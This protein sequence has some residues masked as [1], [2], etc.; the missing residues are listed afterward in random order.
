[1]YIVTRM[2]NPVPAEELDSFEQRHAVTLPRSYRSWLGTYGEGTYSGWMNV[3]R[4]DAEVLKP[5]AEYDFWLHDEEAPISQ[6]QIG[7]CISIGSSVDGDFLAIHSGVAGLLWLPRHDERIR[8]WHDMEEGFG[9]QLNRIYSDVY[10]DASLAEPRYFEPWNEL[11]QHTFYHY[12][13]AKQGGLSLQEVAQV[14]IARFEWDAILE[15]QHTCKLFSASMG[16][17]LR[18]N[19][20]Y[21]SEIALFYEA[22]TKAGEAPET[23]IDRVLQE[24][25]CKAI[26]PMGAEESY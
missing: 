12:A 20:A 11:R 13:G 3:Q 22:G 16:G 21:G 9:E 8:L 19:Y 1:M 5:F 17:Y 6:E 4:P 10:S 25:D 26:N 7:E 15:N 14:F 24:L 18:F 23:E 2:L